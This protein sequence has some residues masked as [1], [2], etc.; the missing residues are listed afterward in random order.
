MQDWRRSCPLNAL[1]VNATKTRENSLLKLQT[2][3][4]R[5]WLKR[6]EYKKNKGRCPATSNT[7]RSHQENM[8]RY[9]LLHSY[10]KPKARSGSETRA[11]LL[12]IWLDQDQKICEKI[13]KSR[14][15]AKLH[16]V[17]W[18]MNSIDK[19]HRSGQTIHGDVHHISAIRGGLLFSPSCPL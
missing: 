11:R 16:A 3:Y 13:L 17:T 12:L 7:H 9:P 19:R 2:C 5:N 6:C 4:D 1:Y 18:R 10:R 15:N 8:R 14:E